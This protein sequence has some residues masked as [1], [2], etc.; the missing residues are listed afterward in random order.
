M[1]SLI[2]RPKRPAARTA[3]WLGRLAALA[4]CTAF[5][6]AQSHATPV[7]YINNTDAVP[8]TGSS[9]TGG[10]PANSIGADFATPQVVVNQS[11]D[12]ISLQFS[13]DF[14]NTGSI[15]VAGQN[16]Y[17]A[18]IF[19]A[20]GANAAATPTAYNFAIVLGDQ[21][22]N[23]GTATAGLYQ[24]ATAKT[25]Q[26]VWSGRP[27]FIY[28]GQY[29]LA[30]NLSDAQLAPVA[31]MSGSPVSGWTVTQT[32]SGGILDVTLTA[33]D[34]A[35]LATLAGTDD[36]FWATADCD[37]GPIFE[38]ISLTGTNVPEPASITLF[39][40]GL[41]GLFFLRRRSGV[42]FATAA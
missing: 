11:G 18:D 12:T 5:L 30:S 29:A 22:A 2:F 41:I 3:A 7:T 39:A 14:P 21:V 6:P 20:T 4:A 31:M 40:A 1:I 17:A 8:Y 33:A 26:A 37:N 25:S 10:A 28:G 32:W 42:G 35:A 36:L 34:A 13:T 24:V 27:G 16:A 15:N 19:L 38:E 23:G 9:A